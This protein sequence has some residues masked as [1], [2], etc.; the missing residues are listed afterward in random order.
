M[1]WESFMDKLCDAKISTEE[2]AAM[3][4]DA[5]DNHVSPAMLATC[6]SYLLDR[7]IPLRLDDNAIDVCGTGGSGV[8]TFN[9]ST[10]S[11]FVLSAGGAKVVK[12]G[13]RA[14]SSMSG[15][16]DVLAA[17]GVI[18]C[19]DAEAARKCFTWNNLCFVSAPAFHPALKSVAEARKSLKR[20]SFF[21]VLG[22]LCN[23]AR[24]R[25]QVIG[26]FDNKFL[27]IIAET[28]KLLGKTDVMV[29]HSE[30]GLDEISVSAPA[31]ICT[32]KD[33]KISEEKFSPERM[34]P[35]AALRGGTPEGNA[36][37]IRDVFAGKRADSGAEEIVCVNAAAGFV[38]AGIE[39]DLHDGYLRARD[40]VRAGLALEKLE[41]MRVVS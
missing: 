18:I 29:V 27:N 3:L 34:F 4:A 15:S 6:A 36:A 1:T 32:L 30:D 25:K 33:G 2:K 35:A 12:H 23:P 13:N 40:I 24:I 38:V 8:K 20:P 41:A 5:T 16:S 21:N 11:A 39:D 7:A 37:I 22:P 9:V 31:N 17:L 10:A 28:A 19:A 26:V 14:V